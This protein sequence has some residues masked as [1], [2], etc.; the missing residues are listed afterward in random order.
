MYKSVIL[1][2]NENIFAIEEIQEKTNKHRVIVLEDI[3]LHL[4]NNPNSIGDLYYRGSSNDIKWYSKTCDLSKLPAYRFEKDF[5]NIDSNGVLLDLSDKGKELVQLGCQK[6]IVSYFV[7][8]IMVKEIGDFC[9]DGAEFTHIA[10]PDSLIKIGRN[11]FAYSE[12][13]AVK[14]PDSC[15]EIGE[16]AFMECYNLEYIDFGKGIERIG[17]GALYDCRGF[18]NGAIYIPN[19]V[20][21][22]GED[23]FGCMEDLDFV[24]DNRPNSISIISDGVDMTEFDDYDEELDEPFDEDDP[25]NQEYFFGAYNVNVKYLRN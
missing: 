1:D 11:A 12:I 19:S 23:A 22:I 10:L 18:D 3:Y 8:G 16:N 7:N 21:E 13:E 9:F 24:V 25:D 17:I 6:I 5:Y 20:K 15:L 14:I 2:D 4:K